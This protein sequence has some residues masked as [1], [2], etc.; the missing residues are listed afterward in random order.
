ML[1]RQTYKQCPTYID[2]I[3]PNVVERSLGP[4]DTGN[5]W[6]RVEAHSQLE[7]LETLLVDSIERRHEAGGKLDQTNEIQLLLA[8][9]QP[10]VVLHIAVQSASKSGPRNLLFVGGRLVAA[11]NLAHLGAGTVSRIHTVRP[12]AGRGHISA[13]ANMC[14]EV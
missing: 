13:M 5:D 8:H 6:A 7:Y 9:N 3:A 11:R 2:T 1:H 14:I 12:E 4:Y 10:P